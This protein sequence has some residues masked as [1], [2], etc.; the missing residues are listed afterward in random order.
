VVAALA[1]ARE[2]P[3][4]RL[5]DA[6]ELTLLVARKD[7]RRHPRVAARWLQRYLEEDL[8]ATVEEAAL[9]ASSLIGT[10]NTLAR[11]PSH[12]SWE[13]V[14]GRLYADTQVFFRFDPTGTFLG[15]QRIN[16]NVR[17]A[18]DGDSFTTVS[19]S[20]LFDP[21]GNL[22]VGGLR[23]TVTGTRIHIDRIPD[24]P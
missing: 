14:S 21:N 10:G 11:G 15:T 13:H 17:L 1:A 20:N 8:A 19:I 9:A 2:L 24:Q 22:V 18:P 3:Q 16:E 5:E 7:P 4:L 6:L 12:G 23:A